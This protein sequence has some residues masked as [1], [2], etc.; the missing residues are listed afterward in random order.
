MNQEHGVS[1]RQDCKAA[2][3]ARSTYRYEAR[4][5]R[6]EEVIDVLNTLVARHPAIGFWQL[7]IA[8][9][10]RDMVGITN[11]YTESTRHWDSIFGAVLRSGSRRA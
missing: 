1:I 2:R 10:R 6:D 7:S 5:K 9:A 4:P 3:L 11:G 8:C